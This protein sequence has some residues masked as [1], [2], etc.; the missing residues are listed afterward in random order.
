MSFETIASRLRN[1]IVL[2]LRNLALPLFEDQEENQILLRRAPILAGLTAP[3]CV[4]SPA[5]GTS[6][7]S[8]AGM[9]TR[10]FNSL[11]TFCFR[12]EDEE[13]REVELQQFCIERVEQAF[14]LPREFPGAMA[15]L[16]P[17]LQEL[18]VVPAEPFVPSAYRHQV[19]VHRIAI[20]AEVCHQS[21]V[22]V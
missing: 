9:R 4:V 3:C 8:P 16:V 22:L 14:H 13:Q 19:D 21:G 1:G 20:G 11:V 7:P 5:R 15:S 18:R 12:R 2:S 17:E 10:I 6:R